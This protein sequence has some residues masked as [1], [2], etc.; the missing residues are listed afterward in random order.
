MDFYGKIT[1]NRE[2]NQISIYNKIVDN[3]TEILHEPPFRIF[4]RYIISRGTFCSRTKCKWNAVPRPHYLLG[5]IAAVTQA[6]SEGRS[7][8]SIV[9]FG[10]ASGAGLLELERYAKLVEQEYDINI[11]VFGFDTGCGLPNLIAEYRDH[12]D[13]WQSGDY[14][15]SEEALRSRLTDRTKLIIGDIK[16]TIDQFSTYLTSPIGFIAFDLDLYSST[17]NALR[18]LNFESSTYLNRIYI[19]F[20]DIDAA[21]NHKYAGVLT[22]INE[23]NER[24]ENTKIDR[25]RGVEYDRIWKD[26][27]W[28]KKMYIARNLKAISA[29]SSRRESRLL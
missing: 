23:F 11:K 21:H 5:V 6:N 13:W 19:Y 1:R 12:P 25:W 10:V 9:E 8:I 4:A 26:D 14:P 22:A 28:L 3:L 16:N 17:K 20:D 24:D 18:I 15:M 7:N 2:L 27:P 29:C